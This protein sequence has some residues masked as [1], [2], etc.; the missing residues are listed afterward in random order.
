MDLGE[1]Y[2]WMKNLKAPEES[3]QKWKSSSTGESFVFWSLNN[4]IISQKPY[5]DWAMEHY[6]IPFL[7]NMYFE[8]RLMTKKQWEQIRGLSGWTMEAQ[9][10]AVWEDMVFI[11]CVQPPPSGEPKFDSNLQSRFVLTSSLALQTH[12]KFINK[13]LPQAPESENSAQTSSNFKK[14]KT[15]LLSLEKG[16]VLPLPPE[17]ENSAQTSSNFKKDKTALLSL[18]K[19]SV[20]PLPP[21]G[22]NSAQT[23]SNFKKDKTAL[24][25]LEKGSTPPPSGSLPKTKG[26]TEESPQKPAL[27]SVSSAEAKPS[28]DGRP[29]DTAVPQEEILSA[30]NLEDG[31]APIRP[32][33]LKLSLPEPEEERIVESE[34]ETFPG[35]APQEESNILVMEDFKPKAS[36]LE[37]LSSVTQTPVSSKQTEASL[38]TEDKDFSQTDVTRFTFNNKE[39]CYEELWKKI[40]P[41]FCA[42]MLLKVQGDKIFHQAWFGRVKVETK[43]KELADMKDHSLFKI[44]QKGHPYHGFIVDV[45]ANKKFFSNIGWDSYPKHITAIPIKSEKQELKQIFAGLSVTP[46]NREK[47]KSIERAVSSFFQSHRK[48]ISSAA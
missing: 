34:N 18:E 46:L 22:A 20:L 27:F 24:L 32:G 28:L 45:P 42:F 2:P 17:S 6:Q 15:A 12:W 37:N 4:K 47:I 10:V 11:G 36:A 33:N 41:V 25:S 35:R 31:P 9:P 26:G 48:K 14:D 7:E 23:S 3:F 43:D 29:A 30:L 13:L 5:F 39:K 19:G 38:S 16:S 1:K 40:Q 21:A 8:K 44:V